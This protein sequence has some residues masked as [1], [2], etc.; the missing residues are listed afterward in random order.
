MLEIR[1][2]VELGHLILKYSFKNYFQIPYS[3][4]NDVAF[5]LCLKTTTA[6]NLLNVHV[7]HFTHKFYF[8]GGISSNIKY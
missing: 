3:Q 7:L 8:L 2:I 1:L 6:L 4:Y 5:A